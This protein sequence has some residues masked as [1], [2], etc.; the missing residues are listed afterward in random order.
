MKKHESKGTLLSRERQEKQLH[1]LLKITRDTNKMLRAERNCTQNKS[2]LTIILFLAISGYG[3]Y[4]FEKYK[5]KIIETQQRIQELREHLNLRQ[6]SSA[7]KWG[8]LPSQFKESLRTYKQQ[9]SLPTQ[10][11]RWVIS[12][13]RIFSLPQHCY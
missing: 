3:Y 1:D 2:S 6:K 8:T 9:K 11:R 13:R 5:I 12:A 10:K 7:K 4:L